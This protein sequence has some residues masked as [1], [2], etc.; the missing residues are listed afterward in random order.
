MYQREGWGLD[1]FLYIVLLTGHYLY[2]SIPQGAD[3]GPGSSGLEASLRTN[4]ISRRT[5]S[6]SS[7]AEGTVTYNREL[8]MVPL[9][10]NVNHSGQATFLVIDFF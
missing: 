7:E 6:E 8:Y 5:V 2:R 10:V 1:L 3:E 4:P 9:H